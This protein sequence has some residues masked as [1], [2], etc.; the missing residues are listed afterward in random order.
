[1]F[2]PAAAVR[3]WHRC[4]SSSRELARVGWI[5]TG[6][7]GRWMCGHLMSAGH[8]VS[9]FNRTAS[10][11]DPLVALGATRAD[12]P[13]EVAEA[14][15][16]V[17]S[18]VGYPSD[19][20]SIALGSEGVFPPEGGGLAAGGVFV[21][22]TTSTP[23][24]AVRISETAKARGCA[25][26]DAPVSGGDVG[27]KNAS[28]VIMVG[29]EPMTLDRVMP[30]FQK[31][32]SQ[33]RLMGG[34]GAGQTCKAVNQTVIACNMVGMAEGILLAHRSGLDPRAVVEL[35]G[36]GAA[37]SFSLTKLG[38]R[39]LS[40]DLEPGF[41]VDHFVKDLGIAL[42]ITRQRKLALPGLA[43]ATQLFVALQAQGL[44]KKGT[45]AL[46][47]ALESLNGARESVT[48]RV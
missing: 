27:A 28:L 23:E 20:E 4:L 21:D 12:S 39:A 19:V 38:P 26:L 31:M 14:S 30:L 6:V 8:S 48:S 34:H 2:A 22:M 24:L 3:S 1:M 44:G 17:F 36:G 10:K 33:I 40:G 13:R 18:I 47:L 9:V 15:D 43:L 25:S 46:I 42:D 16:V 29:G 5:G 32:G 45:Q 41:F 7:M 37:G 11:C 35:I